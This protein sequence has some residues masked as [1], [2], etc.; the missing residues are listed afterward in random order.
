MELESRPFD[1]CMMPSRSTRIDFWPGHSAEL[2]LH[3]I[4]AG[5]VPVKGVAHETP[6]RFLEIYTNSPHEQMAWDEVERDVL[7]RI[8][9]VPIS[10]ATH[11]PQPPYAWRDATPHQLAVSFTYNTNAFYRILCVLR[12]QGRIAAADVPGLLDAACRELARIYRAGSH[13][14]ILNINN[15]LNMYLISKVIER[16]VGR[17][18]YDVEEQELHVTTRS[19]T[20]ALMLAVDRTSLPTLEKMAIA[21]G[22]GISFIESRLG[23]RGLTRDAAITV[24]E[25]SYAHYGRRLS[26][27]DRNLLL[28]MINSR[29]S[30]D[31]RFRLAVILDDTTE[32]VDDL[33]WLQDVVQ[34]YP[35]LMV[36][37]LVNTAQISI[38]FSTHM[39]SAVEAWT[40]LRRLMS[41]IGT[42]LVVTRT[43]CPFISFQTNYLSSAATRA[44]H[45]A[46]AVYVKGANFF[47][48]CQIVD[49]PT[50]HA[51]VVFGPISRML[52]GLTDGAAVFAYLPPGCAGYQHQGSEA[53]TVTLSEVIR[54]RTLVA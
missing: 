19:L 39:L 14:I 15:N 53:P 13:R 2:P 30:T 21:V 49:K 51:F 52:T 12:D 23:E 4:A 25:R 43:Y 36:D 48:T 24:Q 26:I 32:T 46:D 20:Q 41:R 47:E 54:Q 27:D 28:N 44:I 17:R 45:L 40:P 34:Q 8:P 18:A 33:L 1:V 9:G 37:L 6:L 31:G 11:Y 7:P 50:F 5:A 3:D 42:Q 22:T 38:N 16:L 29:A 10:L 35:H